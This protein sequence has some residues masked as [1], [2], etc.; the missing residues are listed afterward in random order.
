MTDAEPRYWLVLDLAR[1][2]TARRD[3]ED[4]LAATFA[5]LR[6]LLTFAGGSIQ[7]LDEQGWI[8]MAAT[9]PAAP[10]D[11]L[12]LR[13]PLGSTV[14]GRVILT[15]RP[16]YVPDVMADPT[17]P[18]DGRKEHL[19]PDG[20]RSYYGVP[21]LADG[22]AIGLI[23]IDSPEPDA[24]TESDRL[25]LLSI[26]P[27]V[28]AAIQNARAYAMHTEAK[29]RAAALEE[30]Q[31][32][33]DFAVRALIE[34]DVASAQALLTAALADEAPFIRERIS[35]AAAEVEVIAASLTALL[36]SAAASQLREASAPGTRSE[37]GQARQVLAPPPRSGRPTVDAQPSLS[38]TG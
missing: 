1:S 27:I 29:R 12:A 26:G 25:L 17:I 33:V 4:V 19:S 3:L 14:G 16:V 36:S 15:E 22:R 21:L 9:E 7:L 32:S 8:R 10:A 11:V 35:A 38:T 13:I 5:G 18:V 37:V 6:Q 23:Q 2:I 34:Q 20:V 30:R 24:W 28:A 31:R